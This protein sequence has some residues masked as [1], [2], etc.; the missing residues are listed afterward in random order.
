MGQLL[1][2]VVNV[3]TLQNNGHWLD[4][5]LL[6]CSISVCY[7]AFLDYMIC[8]ADFVMYD[9]VMHV[10]SVNTGITNHM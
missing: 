9:F 7:K 10:F 3:L 8:R 2:P 5:P 6:Y 4:A 1:T